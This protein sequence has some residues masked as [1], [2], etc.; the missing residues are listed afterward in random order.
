MNDK[1]Q[2]IKGKLR[3]LEG[4]ATFNMG[5]VIKGKAEQR[6]GKVREKVQKAKASI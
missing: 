1:N 3:E 5:Q 4:K 2:Q 6:I